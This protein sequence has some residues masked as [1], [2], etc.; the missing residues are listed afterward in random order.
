MAKKHDLKARK[1]QLESLENKDEG[2][3]IVI[4]VKTKLRSSESFDTNTN[5]LDYVMRKDI[6]NVGDLIPIAP[7]INT[8]AVKI[9]QYRTHQIDGVEYLFRNLLDL[10]TNEPTIDGNALAWTYLGVDGNPSLWNSG[11][12]YQ[13]FDV[14][15]LFVYRDLGGGVNMV[16]KSIEVDNLNNTPETSPEFWEEIGQWKS[17][18]DPET[19]YDVTDFVV[20]LVSP[21]KNYI[22][23]TTGNNYLFFQTIPDTKTWQLVGFDKKLIP[24]PW[25]SEPTP[26]NGVRWKEIDAVTYQFASTINWNTSEPTLSTGGPAWTSLGFEGFPPLFNSGDTYN[27]DDYIRITISLVQYIYKSKVDGN[28]GNTPVAATSDS[29]WDYIGLSKGFFPDDAPYGLDDVVLDPES[30]ILFQSNVADNNYA[31]DAE[32]TGSWLLL[33][34]KAGGEPPTILTNANLFEESYGGVWY[35]EID[36]PDGLTVGCIDYKIGTETNR[37]SIDNAVTNT[38]NIP[39]TKISGFPEI[40]KTSSTTITI[41]LI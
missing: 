11:T 6:E 28:I 22:S 4:L 36:V 29:F 27:T 35:C 12:T 31:L 24:Q 10:N 25:T 39:N 26:I 34:T 7:W 20:D 17:S 14:A 33:G 5:A 9:K 21:F 37:L 15:P 8:E 13:P 19:T 23:N 2:E 40:A 16:Y 3:D 38:A 32:I 1:I 41:K 18:Y 30:N